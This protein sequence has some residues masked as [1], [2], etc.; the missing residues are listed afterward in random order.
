MIFDVASSLDD[1]IV[2]YRKKDTA[3]VSFVDLGLMFTPLMNFMAWVV[4]LLKYAGADSMVHWNVLLSV[5]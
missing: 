4:V 3:E 5:I 1:L 2:L